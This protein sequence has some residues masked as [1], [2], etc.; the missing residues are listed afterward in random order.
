MDRQDWEFAD[1]LSAKDFEAQ[2][3]S[4]VKR[5]WPTR[6]NRSSQMPVRTPGQQSPQL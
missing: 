4:T 5:H 3:G 1:T 2:I 6:S